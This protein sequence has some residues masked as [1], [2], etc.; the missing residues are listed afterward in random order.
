MELSRYH[1]SIIYPAMVSV[2]ATM[3]NAI[4][5]VKSII[6]SIEFNN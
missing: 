6:N 3:K 2:V 1:A 4:D 5:D